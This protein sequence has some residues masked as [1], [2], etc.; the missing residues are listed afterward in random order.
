MKKSI[1]SDK[2]LSDL[3]PDV[4]TS[5]VN[6]KYDSANSLTWEDRKAL[7]ERAGSDQFYDLTF[8]QTKEL[9]WV[10]TTLH[11][12]NA[13]RRSS[14][15][16]AR[17]YGIQLSSEKLCRVGSGPHVLK[18]VRVTLN[19]SNLERLSKYVDLWRKGMELA[20][21]TRDRI[22]TRRAQ[23]QAHRANGESSWYW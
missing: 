11:I 20:G 4:K 14:S 10:L 13:S 16:T 7:I 17:S 19:K 3:P 5:D 18:T 1:K 9:G 8:Y 2:P 6:P 23:G 12:S 21:S 22:S 15:Q